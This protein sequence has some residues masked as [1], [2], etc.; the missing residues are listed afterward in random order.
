[1]YRREMSA[2]RHGKIKSSVKPNHAE[3]HLWMTFLSMLNS[4]PFQW[5]A[6]HS[7]SEGVTAQPQRNGGRSAIFES[8]FRMPK[9][10]VNRLQGPGSCGRRCSG[11]T[12]SARTGAPLR[13][14]R[15]PA[16]CPGGPAGV[17][18]AA[19]RP[20]PRPRCPGR[21]RPPATGTAPAPAQTPATLSAR[22]GRCSGSHHSK[23]KKGMH[24]SLQDTT[25]ELSNRTVAL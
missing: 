7:C 2:C 19:A 1:M 18:A 6:R 5:R 9:R 17:P 4:F 15:P 20:R 11:R 8:P 23:P 3:P 21:C 13:A 22:P 10:K 16:S 24:A 12:S 14:P 25:A